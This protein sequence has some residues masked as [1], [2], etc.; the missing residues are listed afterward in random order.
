MYL[1]KY[2]TTQL[3]WSLNDKIFN[4]SKNNFKSEMSFKML[5]SYIS[6]E[7]VVLLYIA[8]LMGS[9]IIFFHSK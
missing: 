9:I 5:F 4:F 8:F 7:K 2:E 1:P 6:I 3:S